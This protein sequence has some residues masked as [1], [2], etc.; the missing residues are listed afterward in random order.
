MTIPP[1]AE[2]VEEANKDATVS[3]YRVSVIYGEIGKRKTTTACSMVKERGLLLSSDDSWKVLLND[4]HKE[5][6]SKI[7]V[8]R[9]E[10]ISQLEH[11]DFDGYDT[12]IWDTFSASAATYVDLIYDEANWAKP[13]REKIITTNKELKGVSILAA[14]DYRVVRDVF[15][16]ALTPIFNL[17]AHLVFTSQVNKP[18]IGLSKDETLRPDIPAA[19]FKIVAEKA[20][21][22]GLIKPY[23]KQFVIEM[24]ENS[25]VSLGKSRIENLEGL[26]NVD[27]FVAKYKEIVF[28]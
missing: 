3:P 7:K 8:V 23:N 14:M 6:Y 27:N 21:I 18:F 19:T 9:L 15:R 26:M 11:I 25:V 24:T 10:G 22:I 28:K 20:D 2:M 13:Y 12:I 17:P 16:P 5:L 4:R 1:K